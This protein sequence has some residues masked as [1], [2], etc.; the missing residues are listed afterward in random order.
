MKRFCFVLAVL[1][2]LF[3]RTSVAQRP[4]KAVR[5][6]AQA[7]LMSS[8]NPIS[9]GDTLVVIVRTVLEEHP[10]CEHA[11]NGCGGSLYLTSDILG[12]QWLPAY[13]NDPTSF[14]WFVTN[15]KPGIDIVGVMASEGYDDSGNSGPRG[16]FGY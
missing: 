2:L 1:V 5:C 14:V 9:K 7:C 6:Y 15:A 13:S 16:T 12:N 10:P 8:W 11:V 3:A 4:V